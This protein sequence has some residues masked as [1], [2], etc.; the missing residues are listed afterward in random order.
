V[1]G[2]EYL[3]KHFDIPP[4]AHF[5]ALQHHERYDGTGYP[6]ALKGNEISEIGRIIA[7]ADVYDALIS[8]RPYR[9][10]LLPS[11][12]MEYIMGGSSTMFDPLYV[13]KFTRKVAAFPLGTIVVL[14]DG[15]RGIVV[16]NYEDCCTRPCIRVISGNNTPEDTQYIDL[17][18]D[19]AT[20]NL[21]I[22]EIERG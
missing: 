21:T 18:D 5:G 8:D 13:S 9:R 15:T 22:V 1:L 4:K 6:F 17:R 12:A 10:A 19:Y 7:I 16:K 2:Y 20:T 3:I 11:D 14:S